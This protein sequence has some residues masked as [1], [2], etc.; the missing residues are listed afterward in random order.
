ML[1]SVRE[2]YVA[3]KAA[4][5]DVYTKLQAALK[6][7]Q[8]RKNCEELADTAYALR[9]AAELMHD[10]RKLMDANGEILQ[11]AACAIYI[12]LDDQ[13]E[14]IRTDYVTAIPDMRVMAMMPKKGTPEYGM[15]MDS[16]GIPRRMWDTEERCVNLHWPG[17]IDYVSELAEQGKPLPFGLDPSKTFPM[18]RLKMRRRKDVDAQ[19]D[20]E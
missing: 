6:D 17:L 14:P 15:F 8:G 20:G 18:Y 4:H 10:L 9:E 5:A 11:K 3:A 7:I 13:T 16:L 19:V 1:S 2:L 12:T